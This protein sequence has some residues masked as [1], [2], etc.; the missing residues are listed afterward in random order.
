MNIDFF[1]AGLDQTSARAVAREAERRGF[2]VEL[3][4]ETHAGDWTCVCTKPMEPTCEHVSDIQRELDRLCKP[5]GG[6]SEG[7]GTSL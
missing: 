2:T 5:L 6:H 7:W 4:C 3:C 1:V